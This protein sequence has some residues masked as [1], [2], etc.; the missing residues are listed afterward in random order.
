M[1]PSPPGHW[2][3]GTGR[4]FSRDPV[5][6]I[7]RYSKD[8]GPVWTMMSRIRKVI[9]LMDP[10]WIKYVL[11]ENQKNYH[12]SFGYDL[13]RPLLGNGLLTS[14]GDFWMR[15]RRLMQPSFHKTA[16]Q[17]YVD[18]MIEEAERC[19]DRLKAA[20]AAGQVVNISNEMSRVTMAIVSR[21]MLGMVV[22]GDM[23]RIAAS[24][25]VANR[26]ANNRIQQPITLPMYVPTPGNLKV[27]KAL[28]DLDQIIHAL[29]SERRKSGERGTDLLSLLLET[30]DADTGESMSDQQLRDE[31]AT[32]FIAGHE[33]T[34]NALSWTLYALSANQ[35]VE[36]K[37]LAEIDAAG[38]AAV[39]P[40]GLPYVRLVA[41][42]SLRLYPP[43]WIVGR[44]PIEDD[45]IAGHLIP[46]G[47]NVLM[48]TVSIQRNPE[49][50]PDPLTYKPERHDEER[51]KSLPKYAY[52][53][54]GGGPRICIGLNFAWMEMHLLLPILLR[55]L[56]FVNSREQHPALEHLIT[57]HPKGGIWLQ[58]QLRHG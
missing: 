44:K 38:S 36:E 18:I 43:A 42:E 55:E 54:F 12:K 2:L 34:A 16:I 56:R 52:F 9:I 37:L 5:A 41:K 28:S 23:D 58:P 29:I 1:P 53:P 21:S 6:Y 19:V 15:Q 8:Y 47:S 32:I 20:A 51:V 50:W 49:Y 27:R 24:L 11:A 4:E 25:E 57:L 26:D 13:L 30:R 14:E 35:R 48:P 39:D 22:P 3:V 40:M 17:S 10:E 46:K 31:I 45:H 7:N 33:T